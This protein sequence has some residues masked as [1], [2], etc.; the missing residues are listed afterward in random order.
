[1]STQVR[2]ALLMLLLVFC[3]SSCRDLTE[4]N[5]YN[6]TWV[7]GTSVDNPPYEF[8]QDGKIVGFDIDLM[9]AIGQY[10]NHKIEFRN[11]EFYS[12]LAAL[13]SNH[14][15]MVIAGISI[16]SERQKKVLFSIPYTST[17]VAVL[18]RQEQNLKES[19]DLKHKTI[20][21]QLGSICNLIA[22]DMS[23]QYGF[24]TKT[25]ASNFMLIEELKNGTIDAILLEASQA[26]KFVSQHK[27]FATFVVKQYSSSFSIALPVK[28]TN[29]QHMLN[30]A[31]QHLKDNGTISSLNDKWR[32]ISEE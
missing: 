15:D 24:Y 27:D 28:Y 1:M 31:I 26:I 9:I 4:D 6:C 7:V 22:C 20:G 21:T 3:I 16:T 29:Y 11:M 10:L 23:T 25:L 18:F 13:D 17:R 8:I 32:I 5:N 14:V 19:I 30:G 12:L 2:V